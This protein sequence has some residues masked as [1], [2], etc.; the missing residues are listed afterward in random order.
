MSAIDVT[1]FY[2]LLNVEFEYFTIRTNIL[3]LNFIVSEIF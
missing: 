2:M 1:I 3:I